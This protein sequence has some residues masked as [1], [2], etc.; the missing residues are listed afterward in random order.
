MNGTKIEMVT[1]NNGVKMPLL[2]MGIYQLHG[3]AC[4]HAVQEA[5]KLGYRLFDTAQMYGNEKELGN[6]LKSCG[7]PREELFVTTK[8]YSPSTSYTLAKTAIEKS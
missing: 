8:L 2:G 3:K 5:I 4:E 6:A 7:M 1:L